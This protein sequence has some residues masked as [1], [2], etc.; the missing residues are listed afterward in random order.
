MVGSPGAVGPSVLGF[1]TYFVGTKKTIKWLSAACANTVE[2]P[3]GADVCKWIE[4]AGQGR[5]VEGGVVAL[6][7]LFA[8][9]VCMA[10]N[11]LRA[12][13]AGFTYKALHGTAM[14]FGKVKRGGSKKV[15][16]WLFAVILAMAMF[17]VGASSDAPSHASVKRSTAWLAAIEPT[18]GMA[19]EAMVKARFRPRLIFPAGGSSHHPSGQ[20]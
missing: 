19:A 4:F 17:K 20:R 3:D 13:I 7:V 11:R 1:S 9:L 15:F 12:M 16:M 2:D 18:P 5:R 14:V 10:S 6:M 8:S